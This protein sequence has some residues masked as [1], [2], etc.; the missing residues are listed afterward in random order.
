[1]CV[2]KTCSIWMCS[3]FFM[4]VYHCCPICLFRGFIFMCTSCCIGSIASCVCTLECTVVSLHFHVQFGSS[5]HCKICFFWRLVLETLFKNLKMLWTIL[6]ALAS[7]VYH[8]SSDL[9]SNAWEI[10]TQSLNKNVLTTTQNTW[11]FKSLAL[12]LR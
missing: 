6:Y 2:C 9:I 1:M 4:W 10:R 12:S 3:F 11:L 7:S 8:W 5:W